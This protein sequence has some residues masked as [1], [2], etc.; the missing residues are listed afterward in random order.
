MCKKMKKIALLLAVVAVGLAARAQVVVGLQGG[1]FQ[2]KNNNP[3]LLINF[4]STTHNNLYRDTVSLSSVESSIVGGLQVGYQVT[5]KIYVGVMAGIV[6]Q[7]GDTTMSRDY[8]LITEAAHSF[9]TG[10]WETVNEHK[11][12][13]VRTG[14]T[15]AP[16]VKYEFARYGNM[17]FNLM[18]QADITSLGYSTLTES[19]RKPFE[20]NNEY[21]ELD[22]YQDSVK[23]FSFGISLR[24]TLVYEFSEHLSAELSLDF[25]S[26]G[27]VSEKVSHDGN[28]LVYEASDYAHQ[29]APIVIGPHDETASTLYAGLNTLMQTL[30]WESPML[31]LGFNWK[32]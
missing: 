15:V 1:Y 32:F 29:N 8:M 28:E 26:I 25:L 31:R 5:P 11:F 24:P 17:H 19:F 16:Q 18:L 10:Q 9:H 22:P 23:Y 20:N 14:W 3:T 30:R 13:H 12:R 2:Q 6:K 7:S 4:G 21:V 27:Y